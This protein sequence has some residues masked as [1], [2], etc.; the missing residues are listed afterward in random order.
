MAIAE[1]LGRCSFP[2]GHLHLGVSGGADS[3]A[4]AVVVQLMVPSEVSGILFTANPASGERAEIII[5]GSFGLGEAVVSGQVT[6]DTYIINREDLSIQQELL[7][8][9]ERQIVA[10]GDNGVRMVSVAEEDRS[11]S[12]ISPEQLNE[13]CE[14]ALQIE[15]LYE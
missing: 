6:P 15:A 3:V 11:K 5:N 10:D 4:M 9:K 2:D 13:L 12:S 14:T 8:P 7:G 1:L